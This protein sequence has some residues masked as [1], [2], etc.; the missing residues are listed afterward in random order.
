MK[1]LRQQRHIE[2]DSRKNKENSWKKEQR[3]TELQQSY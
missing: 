3:K 2:V 1:L